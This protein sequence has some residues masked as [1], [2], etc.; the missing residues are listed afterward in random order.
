MPRALNK[1][2]SLKIKKGEPI[3]DKKL[4]SRDALS[5]E[6]LSTTAKLH[7]KKSHL[8]GLQ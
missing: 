8:K 3:N 4:R 2:L 5:V 7:G 6:M 1:I